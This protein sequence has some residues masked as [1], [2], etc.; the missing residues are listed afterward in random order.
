MEPVA[1]RL[2]SHRLVLMNASQHSVLLKFVRGVVCNELAASPP[3]TRP[4]DVPDDAGGGAFVT[5]KRRKR[6]RG[7]M[8]VFSP[9]GSLLDT[10]DSVARSAC[11][12]PRFQSCPVTPNEAP[13]LSIEVSLLT[14]PE[15]VADPRKI[16]AGRHGIIVRRGNRSGCFL[17]QVAVERGWTAAEF[18][19]QCCVAKA[20]LPAD[21]WQDPATEVLSFM[22]EVFGEQ[23]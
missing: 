7:C 18:L 10:L 21:A 16:E 5:L 23:D 4:S 22:A 9:S 12:D 8:G 3:P 15:P 17:P 20:E 14:V 11:R 19:S 13:L 6:L 2:E 1:R